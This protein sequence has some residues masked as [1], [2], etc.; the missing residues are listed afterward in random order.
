MKRKFICCLL[1]ALLILSAVSCG[2][3]PAET[4]EELTK[5][6][7]TENAEIGTAIAYGLV[8]ETLQVSY[9]SQIT[10]GEFCA[11]L[12]N[13][14]VLYDASY[15]EDWL[16]VSSAY[17]DANDLMSRMEGAI[18][19]FY[20]AEC[21]GLDEIGYTYNIP[22][23]DLISDELD[24]YANVTFDYPL[25]PGIYEI[26]YNETIAESE[27]YSWLCE[28]DY[29]DN[30]KR[31]VERYSYINGLTYFDYDENYDLHLG[32][33]F[34]REAAICAVKRLYE[35]SWYA[36]YVPA[37]T[38]ASTI[39]DD[40][41]ALAESMPTVSTSELPDWKGYTL[42]DLDSNDYGAG[43]AYTEEVVALYAAEGFDFVRVPFS[44]ESIFE[45]EDTSSVCEA[46]MRNL[47]ELLTW[48][49]QY[50]IHVCIDLHNMPGFTT[51]ADDSNDS[52]FFD[53]EQQRLFVAFWSFMA[54]YFQNVPPQLLS[55]NL[56]NEPHGSDKTELDSETYAVVMQLAIDVVHDITP[57]RVI[58]VDMLS[59][60]DP[61]YELADTDTVQSAHLYFL[62]D[63]TDRWPVEYINGFIHRNN[64]ELTL[65]GDFSAGT[66]IT[67][68]ISQFHAAGALALYADGVEI[69]VY[70]L[71]GESIGVNGCVEIG[72]PN[73]DGEWFG[74][75]GCTWMV[76]LESDAET[77]LL[78]QEGE[79]SWWYRLNSITIDTEDYSVRLVG[80]NSVVKSEAVPRLAIAAD[81]SVSS[82][83]ANTLCSLN[84]MVEI[85][86]GFTQETGTLIMVQE[87]GFDAEND[88][89]VTL[90]AADDLLAALETYGIPWCS[91]CGEHGY[92]FDVRECQSYVKNGETFL[93]EGAEIEDIGDYWMIDVGLRDV[94]QKYVDP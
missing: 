17:R 36:H 77:L 90:A 21:T 15:M 62:Y 16:A 87:L 2:A 42:P 89:D 69:A 35:T 80:S 9:S 59:S 73:T 58:F 54:S 49:A 76:R 3:A 24:F 55:F 41:I 91:W 94:F 83:V 13:L 20:L 33:A 50:G 30:A 1:A 84:D 66:E 26:Y 56:L 71:G 39:S 47:D 23:E 5:E 38:L 52:M 34:T 4:A 60:S 92:L 65:E 72:E 8:P 67:F 46:V 75:E 31:F 19:L 29:A 82:D 44:F 81:G 7:A 22:L 37:D 85:L 88:Y 51:D 48:C 12:D 64:G 28:N 70:S 45:G 43:Y 74:Y 57:G 32:D 25:L 14:V 68:D 78:S 11:L 6:T 10:Y 18:V 79:D 93:R 40:T 27:N 86:Y 61:V 53:E 63:E